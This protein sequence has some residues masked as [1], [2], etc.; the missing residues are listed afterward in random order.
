MNVEVSECEDNVFFVVIN[1]EYENTS[2]AFEVFGNGNNYGT[3]LYEDLPI[4]IDGLEGN[5]DLEYEF[6]VKDSEDP[7]CASDVGIGV[8]CCDG[9]ECD[10]F[11]LDFDISECDG[12]YFV[13]EVS[14][15]YSGNTSESFDWEI[16][17]IASG[18]FP[19]VALP[20]SILIQNTTD[21]Q[22]TFFANEN[23]N[24]DCAIVGTFG[25][26]C[27]DEEDCEIDDVTAEIIVCEDD[28]YD[29]EINFDYA[30]TSGS[31][32]IHGNGVE[33]GSFEYGDLP[34]IIT[35]LEADCDTEYEFVITDS[36][37]EECSDFVVIGT[38]CCEDFNQINGLASE[39]IID[40]EA[41]KVTFNID[42]TT[43]KDC[44]IEVYIDGELTLTLT[45]GASSFT[46]GP[47]E[48]GQEDIFEIKLVNTCSGD[49]MIIEFDLSDIDCVTNVDLPLDSIDLKW[50]MA[51][52]LLSVEGEVPLS[53][54]I[55]L[56]NIHGALILSE[57]NISAGWI[58]DLS[59]LP[60]G[61]YVVR[62][63]EHQFPLRRGFIRKILIY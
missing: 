5:C 31:F 50:N 19:F 26:P 46:I 22:F 30:N 28:L 1:F 27:Y 35:G 25:N 16:P 56:M 6:I 44:D 51:Q 36:E 4:T 38:I 49:E 21:S 54:D 23:D 2:D 33:Y 42:D 14:F 48:C 34:V 60:G 40:G 10:L 29:V 8:I 15:E 58:R 11:D 9:E 57:N 41:F 55:Q 13:V 24:P 59:D 63:V 47:F 53:V 37:N 18:N 43:L 3:F 20:L 52:K 12:G 62:V 39:T 45:D 32:T 61:I 7:S 17:G